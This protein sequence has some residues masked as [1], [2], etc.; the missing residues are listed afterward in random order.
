M[1]AEEN[2]RRLDDGTELTTFT[3]EFEGFNALEVEVG[4]TGYRGGDTGHG[5]RAYFAL[6]DVV[7]TD[8]RVKIVKSKYGGNDGIEVV[9]GGDS[10]LSTAIEALEF[11]TK[12][13]K[14]EVKRNSTE[15]Y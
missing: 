15:N 2:V 3:K 1:N 5:C 10:E 12:T 13:L 11:I 8:I 7:S 14:K 4:T 6:R 9:L